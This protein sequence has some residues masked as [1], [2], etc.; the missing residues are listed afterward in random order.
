MLSDAFGCIL[1]RY[2]FQHSVHAAHCASTFASNCASSPRPLSGIGRRR[3][4]LRSDRRRRG[5]TRLGTSTSTNANWDENLSEFDKILSEFCQNFVKISSNFS[6]ISI[7]FCIQYSIFQHFS[8]STHFCKILQKILQNFAK[9]LR[10][11]EN[12]AKF[13]K[14]CQKMSKFLQKFP[15]FWQKFAKF[16]REKMIFL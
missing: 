7:N 11:S 9:F 15:F 2:Q 16:A 1:N 12:F 3:I 8:K 13:C 10:V 5:S 14:I 4:Q 6:K